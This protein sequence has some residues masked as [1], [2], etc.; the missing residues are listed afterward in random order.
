MQ[1]ALYLAGEINQVKES[2]PWVRCASGN[3]LTFIISGESFPHDNLTC[4]EFFHMTVCHVDKF[5]H[6]TDFFSTDTV[7]ES[8]TNMRYG[9]VFPPFTHFKLLSSLT[10]YIQTKPVLVNRSDKMY[11]FYAV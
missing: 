8:V 4:G 3:V 5:L 10:V 7:R 2:I 11:L 1:V 6:I 9:H